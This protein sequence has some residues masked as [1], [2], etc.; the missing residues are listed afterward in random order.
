MSGLDVARVAVPCVE[1]DDTI[2]FF[3]ERLGFGL[4]ALWP[5]DDPQRA[6]ISTEGLTLELRRCAEPTDT[7]VVLPGAAPDGLVPPPGLCIEFGTPSEVEFEPLEERV[8]VTHLDDAARWV[9]GRAG[10]RYRD[11]VP[12]R[13]GGRYVAS[14]IEIPEGG[15]VPDYVHFHDVR[16]Q[17]IVCVSGWVRV[18]YEDQGAPFVLEAGDCVLQPPGIRHRVLEASA[19]LEVLEIS[20]PADHVTHRE[21]RIELPTPQRRPDRDFNGQRFVHHVHSGALTEPWRGG[22]LACRDSGIDDATAGV[23]RV[24]F[25]DAA[26]H[27]GTE[28]G[29]T[30]DDTELL[31]L[32]CVGGEA[33]IEL[34]VADQPD[35]RMR[36]GTAVVV[37]TA[38]AFRVCDWSAGFAAVE[39]AV[40]N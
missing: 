33:T 22:P 25:V 37:P 8:V 1:L 36:R 20:S 35:V 34:G 38:V 39:V 23:A 29:W 28:T 30:N 18:V 13:M 5:A 26:G 11:L 12:G 24:Q 6:V 40:E 10:M 16:F 31:L 15:P 27:P 4:D 17:A 19:G 7:V 3:C 9:V 32:Y 21:H 2:A 14:H